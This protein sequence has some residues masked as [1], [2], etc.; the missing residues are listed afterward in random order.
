MISGKR[1]LSRPDER[2]AGADAG[3]RAGAGRD[4]GL[5]AGAAAR[6][7]AD[8]GAGFFVE[9]CKTVCLRIDKL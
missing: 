6:R 4:A 8:L 7:G 2:G 9:F 1:F 5:R 3:F